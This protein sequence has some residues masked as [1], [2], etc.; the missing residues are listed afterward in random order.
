VVI[1]FQIAFQFVNNY[2]P[3]D[4]PVGIPKVGCRI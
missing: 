3:L 2:S 1:L 4:L